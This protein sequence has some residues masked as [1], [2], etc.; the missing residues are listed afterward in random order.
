MDALLNGFMHGPLE[1][2]L[3]FATDQPM[4]TLAGAVGMLILSISLLPAGIV[5]TT[6]AADVEGG[7]R[8]GHAGHARRDDRVQ[9]V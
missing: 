9:D 3:R 6:L 2:A 5:P 8:N 7:F 4:V 1:R